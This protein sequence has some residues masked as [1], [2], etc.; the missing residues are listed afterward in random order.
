MA[1][2]QVEFH[3]YFLQPPLQ[4]IQVGSGNFSITPQVLKRADARLLI[5]NAMRRFVSAISA[6]TSSSAG[7]AFKVAPYSGCL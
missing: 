5:G 2:E 7:I 4:I 1:E 6:R 3:F